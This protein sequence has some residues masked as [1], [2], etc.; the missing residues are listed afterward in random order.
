MENTKPA[1]GRTFTLG[2]LVFVGIYF[3]ESKKKK[4]NVFHGY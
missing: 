2:L 4:K 3:R 1:T